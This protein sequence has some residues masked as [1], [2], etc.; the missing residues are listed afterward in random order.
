MSNKLS[1]KWLIIAIVYVAALL[2]F[3]HLPQ[4]LLPM[5]MDILG[6]DKVIHMISYSM[7]AGLCLLSVG[8]SRS[9]QTY[10]IIFLLLLL[11]AAADEFTQGFMG[12]DC[13]LTDWIADLVG[14]LVIYV[15]FLNWKLVRA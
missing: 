5:E 6:I 4:K 11:F 7:L 13:S 12:R 2:A 10:L 8:R 15:S 3:T 9:L 1:I 14:I